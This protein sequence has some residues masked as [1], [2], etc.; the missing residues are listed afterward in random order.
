MEYAL[1]ARWL[2]LYAALFT[3]GLP[4]VARLLPT[5]TGRGAGLAVPAALV[6]LSLPAYWVGRLTWGPVALAAGVLT[7]L[8]ASALAALDLAALRRGEIRLGVDLDRDAATDAAVVFLAGFLFLVAIRAVDPAVHPG[9]GEKFLDF[10]LLQTLQRSTVLPPEDFWFANEPVKYYYGGHLTATLLSWLTG[11]PPRFAYNLAL[12][13]FYAALVS[14]AF[15]LAGAVGAERGLSRRVAGG[16]AVFF[17]GLASNLVTAGRF[18]LLG[19]PGSLQRPI[20]EYVAGRTDY[21]VAQLLAGAESF[22]YWSASRVIPGT[23]NEFPLFAWLNGDLHAH[24]MGTPT[25]LLA[26]A[27]GYAYYRTPAAALRRRR[28]LLLAVIPLLA[29]WQAIQSTWSFPSV[30]AVGWL[31][32]TFA[33]TDPWTLLPAG[34]RPQWASIRGQVADRK[35][36]ADGRSDAAIVAVK[37]EIG[38]VGGALLVAAAAGVVA[39]ILA[40]PFLLGAAIGGGERSVEF[41]GPD[42]RSGFGSLLLVHGAFLVGLGGF[43]LSQ[44][45]VRRPVVLLGALIAAGYVGYTI[46]FATLAVSVPLLVLAWVALRVERSVGYEAVLVVA[47]MGLVTLVE[48]VYVNEQA[49]PG[50]M[51]TVFKTYMQVWVFLGTA[52]GVALPALV[53][54]WG[55]GRGGTGGSG[56]GGDEASGS[57]SLPEIPWRRVAAVVLVIGLV[58][59]TSIYGVLALGSHFE[60]RPA[61]GPTL[62]ATA[63]VE[64]DHP[65]QVA[66]I[67]WLDDRPGQPTLLEAPGTRSYAG[68]TDGRDRVMYSWAANP[69]SSLTGV[70]TVAGWQHEVGYRGQAAYSERVSDVDAMYTGNDSVRESLLEEYDVRYIWVG[71]S[72]RARYGSISFG[73]GVEIVHQS[74]DVTIYEVTESAT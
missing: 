52:M 22:S 29:A 20:A 24:M 70:P 28:V 5:A 37:R 25:L 36:S 19:L 38:R 62:D 55:R 66:A 59:A 73:E 57:A 2:V 49:G 17:V 67:E 12:A 33:P 31:A 54:K 63:F 15:E 26:A 21:T 11:T 46:G 27:V 56:T 14:A 60:Q 7:L 16:T 18:V 50:R 43:L 74:G 45:S 58:A 47:G 42:L 61:H 4:L 41:L 51:N 71:P 23:I 35:T 13:G 44:V 48:L 1:L 72:E 39:G 40:A 68:G 10:G 3:L 30:L 8:T 65:E 64:T 6:T 9:G 34:Y 69:A 32:A 53:V